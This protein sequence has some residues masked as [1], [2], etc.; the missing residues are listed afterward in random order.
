MGKYFS[1]E[2]IKKKEKEQFDDFEKANMMLQIADKEA[3]IRQIQMEN[4]TIMMELA[5][6]K[7]GL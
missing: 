4:A 1:L 2:I 3:K 6:I 7:G 5:M